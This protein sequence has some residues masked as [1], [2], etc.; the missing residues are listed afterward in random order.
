MSGPSS[1]D[2]K[3]FSCG[4]WMISALWLRLLFLVCT[5][6]DLQSI[7]LKKCIVVVVEMSF[8]YWFAYRLVFI[9]SDFCSLTN[10]ILLPLLCPSTMAISLE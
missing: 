9:V 7:F 8:A 2:L 1:V 3:V 4:V 10:I 6:T 5:E